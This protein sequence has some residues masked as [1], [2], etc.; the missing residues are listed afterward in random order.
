MLRLRVTSRYTYGDY[1][2]NG[3]LLS[4]RKTAYLGAYQAY[5]VRAGDTLDGLAHRMYSDATQYWRIVDLNPQLRF[6]LGLVP[7]TIIRLPL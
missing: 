5:T 4:E 6:P 1:D 7:G 2:D 3:N